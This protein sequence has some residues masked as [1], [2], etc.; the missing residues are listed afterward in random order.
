MI[1]EGRLPVLLSFV[2]DLHPCWVQISQ[3]PGNSNGLGAISAV[4]EGLTG[5]SRQQIA[6]G[7]QPQL[8]IE[9]IKA[10]D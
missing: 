9:P 2:L 5:G 1:A 8:R 4:V 6:A 7:L 3:P 10:S